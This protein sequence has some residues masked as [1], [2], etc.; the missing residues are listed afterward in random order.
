MP[1]NWP[2]ASYPSWPPVELATNWLSASDLDS[3]TRVLVNYGF[4][5]DTPTPAENNA[6]FKDARCDDDHKV[7]GR[8]VVSPLGVRYPFAVCVNPQLRELLV[9]WPPYSMGAYS[10]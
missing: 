6:Y 3:L 4:T 8:M 9:L 5:L 2:P 7:I 10:G 1:I